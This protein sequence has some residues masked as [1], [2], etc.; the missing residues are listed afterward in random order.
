MIKHG[1]T[2]LQKESELNQLLLRMN[3]SATSD[4]NHSNN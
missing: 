3:E 4:S 2:S 1:V